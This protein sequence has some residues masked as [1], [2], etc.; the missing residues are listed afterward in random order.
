MS[1]SQFLRDYLYIALGGNRKGVFRR[2]A[3]LMTTMVLGGLWH[4]AS[5]S[6]VVWGFLHGLYLGLNHAFRA[7]CGK[8]LGDRL[9]RSRAFSLLSWALTML[10]VIVAWV[11]FRA[12]TL[13]GAGRILLGMA[14]PTPAMQ[15]HAQLWNA[16]LGISTGVLWCGVL[17]AIAF[18]VPNSNRIG[19]HLLRQNDP[20]ARALISGAS[21]A[22]VA[23]ML[24]VNIMRDSVS[25]FIYFNF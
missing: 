2:Y 17:C 8:R 24:V 9:D 5:W 19:N 14:S 25:A 13:R 16:G 22:A 21:F 7:L 6:F 3:N 11:V 18:C 23:F 15:V 10:S 20:P 12:E 4:G 1:L